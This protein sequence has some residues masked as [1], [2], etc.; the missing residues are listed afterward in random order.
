[1]HYNQTKQSSQPKE[2]QDL[3]SGISCHS[4][5]LAGCITGG[6]MFKKEYLITLIDMLRRTQ[7]F[8]NS[9]ALFAAIEYINKVDKKKALKI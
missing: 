6:V 9:A 2:S 3:P 7:S 1:M 5:S 4:S 8:E